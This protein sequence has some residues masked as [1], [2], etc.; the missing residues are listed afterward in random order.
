MERIYEKLVE[1]KFLDRPN[2]FVCH[3]EVAGEKVLCHMPNPG[4][5]RELLFPGVTLYMT[6]NRKGL[7]TAY[8]VVGCEKEGRIIYL[9][10]P[11]PTM[12]RP[13]WFS[14]IR[15]RAGKTVSWQE[16]R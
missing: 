10:T 15:F 9:D 13:F 4:R 3:A 16:E 11:E 2:R 14:T 7:R 6:P 8:R 1:G 12:Q 5:M